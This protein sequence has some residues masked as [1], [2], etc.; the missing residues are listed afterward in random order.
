MERY[1]TID[2]NNVDITIFIKFIS[3]LTGKNFIV[4]RRVKGKVTIISPTKIS[5]K[6]AYRVFQSVLE[7][8]G[9]STV[10]A[11]QVIKIV[12]SPDART[13]SI[14]T[15]LKEEAAFPDDKVVTQLI[16]LTYA[17]PD[18]VKRLFA[19]LVSKSSVILSY[20]PTNMLIVTDVYSN[21]QRLMRI[22]KAIDITGIGQEISVVPLEFSDAG[23][24]VTLLKSVFQTSRKP[25]KGGTPKVFQFV[26][27]ERTNTIVLLASAVDT[28]RVKRLIR[29]LDKQ[30]PRGKE[31]I[32]VYYLENATAED[33]AKV[34]QAL[35]EKTSGAAKGRKESPIVSEK[36]KITPDKATNSLIIMADKDDYLVLEEIIEKLDI[37]RTMVYIEALIM[38]VDVDKDFKVG[39]EWTAMT[40]TNYQGRQ[41]AAGGG[42]SGEVTVDTPG[43]QNLRGLAAGTLP[44]GFSLG[45]F[46]EALQIGGVTFPSL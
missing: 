42:Y 13:K 22:L 39:T 11:G 2:F 15:K 38:E 10:Q 20:S 18:Q 17:S 30:V 19:P 31:K 43:Y 33:L 6:E 45:V 44:A 46:T 14:E 35:P 26:A 1:I 24:L 16:P 7:V 37:P 5:V 36:V 40:E 27:D 23:K 8:H 21:I 29:L 12:P 9:Y 3:E 25:K 28:A 34:L 32:H 4:D 41:G